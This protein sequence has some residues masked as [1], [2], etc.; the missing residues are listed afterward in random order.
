MS[1][2]PSAEKSDKE[3]AK[4][5][6]ATADFRHAL[7][8]K[9][10]KERYPPSV[11]AKLCESTSP[12]IYGERVRAVREKYNITQ[13]YLSDEIGTSITNLSLIE[14]GKRN[15]INLDLMYC[16]CAVFEHYRVTPDDLLDR[17]EQQEKSVNAG[18]T[19]KSRSHMLKDTKKVSINVS[20]LY[21]RLSESGEGGVD[22]WLGGY[23]TLGAHMLFVLQS[24]DARLK[25]DADQLLWYLIQKYYPKEA[26]ESDI[27]WE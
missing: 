18:S 23:T 3:I 2:K 4:T 21:Q 14:R 12:K 9:R 13:E 8:L 27:L 24:N 20:E 1:R 10:I 11:Y 22:S 7:A 6:R 25:K 5:R 17:T 16:I 15:E 26:S 19:S